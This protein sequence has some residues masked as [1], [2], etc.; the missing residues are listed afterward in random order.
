MG[1]SSQKMLKGIKT[2]PLGLLEVQMAPSDTNRTP[3]QTAGAHCW[4]R[5]KEAGLS[6]QLSVLSGARGK[7]DQCL[8]A[9]RNM[10]AS[11][12]LPTKS[13]CHISKDPTAQKY[14]NK[15]SIRP[16][17]LLLSSLFQNNYTFQLFKCNIWV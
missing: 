1:L 6:R 14:E 10:L 16:L 9:W 5:R 13:S 8:K 2:H 3:M 15:L 11:T 17:F 7:K 4:R 12:A